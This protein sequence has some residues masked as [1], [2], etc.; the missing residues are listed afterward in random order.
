VTALEADYSPHGSYLLARGYDP[1][2]RLHRGRQTETYR[3]V[4]DCDIVRTVAGRCGLTVGE[5]EDTPGTYDHVSQANVSDWEFLRARAREIGFDMSVSDGKLNFGRPKDAAEGPE[6]GDFQGKQ[7]LQLVWGR[8]LVEFRSRVTAAS[9]VK[10]VQVR[11]WD[12]VNKQALVGSADAT[13]KSAQLDLKPADLAE[14]FASQSYVA[15]D[16]PLAS[17]AEVDA[18]AGAVAEQIASAFAEA[19][20]VAIGNPKLTAGTPI[21]VGLVAAPFAG[22]YTLTQ[23]RHVFHRDGYRT[24]FVV[25][26]RQNRSLLGLA[27]GADSDSAGVHGVVMALVTD[28]N[29]PDKMG[30]VKLKFPWL[31]D[32][33]ESHWARVTQPGA[34]P[35]SGAVFLPEVNDEV[36]VAFEFGDVRRPYVVGGLYNG[37]DKP[38]LG[39]G[40]FDN[41]KVK[42]RGF[43]SRK[44]HQLVF[45]DDDNKSGIALLTKDK[46]IGLALNT[47]GKQVH[48]FCD[49]KV[50][51]EAK[52]AVSVSSQQ[53]VTVQAK[54]NVKLTGDKGVSIQSGSGVVEVKGQTIKLN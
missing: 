23:C 14:K 36:L 47:S 41:G 33:Y 24:H 16:R 40:L 15:C 4:K 48:L 49:G 5:I 25:S 22:R 11:A 32:S 27:A 35:D 21:S 1:S 34:G 51:V 17:Q 26:G 50:V 12:P 43:V 53:D 3:N 44:G 18:A 38:R 8:E 54:G 19:E 37:K 30:R 13:T 52:D 2:H 9:Q 20:G 7:P 6:Q 46:K 39:D 31:S 42:R 45:F 28:N 10:E 29:D